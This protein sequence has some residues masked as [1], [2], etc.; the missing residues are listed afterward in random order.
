MGDLLSLNHSDHRRQPF[1]RMEASKEF[2]E[3]RAVNV[4]LRYEALQFQQATARSGQVL[5]TFDKIVVQEL[6][7]AGIV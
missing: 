5:I 6:R 3:Q 2:I 1:E 7:K 4:R